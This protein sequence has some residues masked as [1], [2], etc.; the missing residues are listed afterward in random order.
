MKRAPSAHCPKLCPD[1][2]Q[3]WKLPQSFS[4]DA[5][6][7]TVVALPS[8]EK[9]WTNANIGCDCL[10]DHSRVLSSHLSPT[11]GSKQ[12]AWCILHQSVSAA[13]TASVCANPRG[14]LS[15]SLLVSA[16]SGNQTKNLHAQLMV[17]TFLKQLRVKLLHKGSHRQLGMRVFLFDCRQSGSECYYFGPD[18]PDWQKQ[19]AG[20]QRLRSE[21]Y[22][23]QVAI[24]VRPAYCPWRVLPYLT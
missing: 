16:D 13:T 19:L 11:E 23:L 12:Q 7:G 9:L 6:Q 21:A 2:S 17:G 4:K 15:Q 5:R 24:R 20:L 22:L 14:T 10:P 8:S 18:N 1:T 3:F